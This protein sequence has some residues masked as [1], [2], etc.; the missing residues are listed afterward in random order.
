MVFFAQLAVLSRHVDRS[1]SESGLGADSICLGTVRQTS[2]LHLQASRLKSSETSEKQILNI[3][4][5]YWKCVLLSCGLER[6]N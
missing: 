6:M 2:A 3:V 4:T 1:V 5:L